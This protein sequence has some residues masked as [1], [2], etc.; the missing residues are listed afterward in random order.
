M[1]GVLINKLILLPLDS[2]GL[3]FVTEVHTCFG[4][5]LCVGCRRLTFKAVWGRR[6]TQTNHKTLR[7][8]DMRHWFFFLALDLESV[9]RT[10]TDCSSESLTLLCS[11][12]SNCF[13]RCLTLRFRSISPTICP[14]PPRVSVFHYLHRIFSP[15]PQ[16]LFLSIKSNTSCYSIP[17]LAFYL[18]WLYQLS[19]LFSSPLPNPSHQ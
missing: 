2:S 13:R 8:Q 3:G 15:K 17:L 9:I 19:I 11:L 14:P 5:L 16:V 1:T 7:I 18:D 12:F 4:A 10:S 6:K